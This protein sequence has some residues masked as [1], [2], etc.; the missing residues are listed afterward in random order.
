[1]LQNAENLSLLSNT[2]QVK[3]PQSILV[4]PNLNHN[5]NHNHD[6]NPNPHTI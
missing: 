5:H 3:L 1:M 4:N 6:S 2:R